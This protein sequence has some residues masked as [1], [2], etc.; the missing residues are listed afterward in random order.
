M[1]ASGSEPDT[2]P[3]SRPLA[4]LPVV[5]VLKEEALGLSI[6][7]GL[8]ALK[9][10]AFGHAD[11]SAGRAGY[12]KSPNVNSSAD[13]E[14]NIGTKSG[15]CLSGCDQ[16]ATH[17]AGGGVCGLVLLGAACVSAVGAASAEAGMLRLAEVSAGAGWVVGSGAETSAGVVVGASVGSITSADAGATGKSASGTSRL[18]R[19]NRGTSRVRRSGDA[20]GSDVWV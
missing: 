19:I 6:G 16:R 12:K 7:V 13:N 18:G 17:E 8:G 10:V 11:G 14:S 4:L 3:L 9:V 2:A 15:G 1:S 20:A 5:H